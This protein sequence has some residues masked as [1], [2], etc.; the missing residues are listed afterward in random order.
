MLLRERGKK[1]ISDALLSAARSDKNFLVVRCALLSFNSITRPDVNSFM[2]ENVHTTD[3]F[4]VDEA[5]QW[6]QAH[7]AEVNER[8]ADMK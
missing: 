2:S 7:S 3:I 1:G 5:E 4:D 6:W 8:L